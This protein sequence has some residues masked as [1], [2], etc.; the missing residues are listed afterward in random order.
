M[1]IMY[2]IYIVFVVAVIGRC[3][4]QLVRGPAPKTGASS[5]ASAL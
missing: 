5:S 3:L 4:R 1:D 2:S